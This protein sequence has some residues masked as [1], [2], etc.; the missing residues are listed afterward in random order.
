LQKSHYFFLPASYTVLHL[1]LLYCTART[2]DIDRSAG[3]LQVR[4]FQSERTPYCPRPRYLRTLYCTVLY[5][6]VMFCVFIVCF[7]FFFF[8]CLRFDIVFYLVF[9]LLI[10]YD[11]L[12]TSVTFTLLTL[13]CT[14]GSV[15]GVN[16]PSPRLFDGHVVIVSYLQGTQ[17]G[18]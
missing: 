7:R 8:L 9:N 15:R 14:G 1:K 13:Y 2:G 12:S 17:N 16:R 18:G 3:H 5:C 11:F 6:T 10:Q 4:L